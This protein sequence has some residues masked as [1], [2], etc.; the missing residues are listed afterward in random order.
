[1]TYP[2]EHAFDDVIAAAAARYT[3]SPALIRAVIAHESQYNPR[4]YRP[5]PTDASRGLMQ[6]LLSTARALGYTGDA[7]PKDATTLAG[8]TFPLTGLF[9]PATNVQLGAQLLRNLLR[10][11]DG[12]VPAV[13]S[14]YNGGVRPSLAFGVRASA[15]GRV[16]L[17]RNTD[18]SCARFFSYEKGQ[19]GNQPY[20]DT[21][22]A[23]Y[24]QYGGTWPAPA[25]DPGAPET[26]PTRPAPDVLPAL[27]T[28]LEAVESS[29]DGIR[30]G[31]TVGAWAA[32]L[33]ALIAVFLFLSRGVF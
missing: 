26:V 17:V 23:L 7:G 1:M 16:C 21:V 10:Q 5:E 25:F 11:L 14:A 12:D 27:K 33:A 18:G 6:L 31:A 9:D 8:G 20:V 24:R 3:V 15:P 32:I 30:T 28:S 2:N 13:L 4:A 22:L 29:H 19:F